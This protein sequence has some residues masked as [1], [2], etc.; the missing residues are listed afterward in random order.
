MSIEKIP[1]EVLRAA[2]VVSQWFNRNNIENWKL[3]S[4][5]SRQWLE[6]LEW[7]VDFLSKQLYGKDA[8]DWLERWDRGETVW[9]IEMGGLSVE[10]E[11]AIYETCAETLR[12]LLNSQYDIEKWE[13]DSFWSDDRD[14][15][16]E[17]ILKNEKIL[18]LG[19]SYAQWSVALNAAIMFYRW[20]PVTVMNDKRVR[21]RH[22]QISKTATELRRP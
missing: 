5:A 6:K 7:K 18:E 2:V 9:A 16:E 20:G 1:N 14:K 22:I 13:D 8:A 17:Y 15:I 10:Y 4:C 19:I 12:H 11:K 3:D 21:D